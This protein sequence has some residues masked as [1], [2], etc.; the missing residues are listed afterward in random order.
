MI[1][2]YQGEIILIIHVSIKKQA[3]YIFYIGH[4][5]RQ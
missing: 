5:V 2:N 4:N 1:E 3:V